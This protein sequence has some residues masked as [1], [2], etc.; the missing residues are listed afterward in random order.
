MT[1]TYR[2]HH[3]PATSITGPVLGQL[4]N[5]IN[6]DGALG[7]IME[8]SG[9]L[10]TTLE[11]DTLIELFAQVMADQFQYATLCY[12]YQN[13]EL[14]HLGQ[15][16]ARYKLNYHLQVLDS[17]LGQ[18][19]M[20]RKRRFDKEEIAQLENLLA[21]LLYPLRNALLYRAALHSAFFDSLTQV[22]NR[23]A[24]DSNFAREMELNRRN[25][26]DLSIIVLDIDFFKKINDRFGHT[27]GDVVLK[28]VAE[29]VEKTIRGSDACYRYGGEEFVVV[30]NATD[31]AGAKLLAERI[32]KQ[33]KQLTID[34]LN[35]IQITLSLGI[36]VMRNKDTTHSLFQRADSALYKAKKNGRNQVAAA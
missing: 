9:K 24:F 19:T 25:Q 2:I 13:Q 17:D 26:T 21:A 14:V 16:Q 28:Q 31:K 27:V 8:L 35:G 4:P 10:Q 3:A 22:K 18:I 15:N 5:L 34:K 23:T 32:R 36:S 6:D 33:V 20:T 29:T 12:Y 1:S 30:L 7:L 11:V